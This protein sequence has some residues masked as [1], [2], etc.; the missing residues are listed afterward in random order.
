QDITADGDVNNT[1]GIY[2]RVGDIGGVITWPDSSETVIP[3]GG[4]GEFK[5]TTP[6][7]SHL[8]GMCSL[9]PID[10]EFPTEPV[11]FWL[12]GRCVKGID[13]FGGYPIATFATGGTYG[14][15][16]QYIERLPSTTPNTFRSLNRFFNYIDFALLSSYPL[17][18]F[19]RKITSM[20]SAFENAKNVP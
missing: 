19:N 9:S 16:S 13:T 7:P 10:G 5:E 3:P 4:I 20:Y 18:V 1:F 2:L 14:L 6:E 17:D 12:G 8:G 15:S 11:Y